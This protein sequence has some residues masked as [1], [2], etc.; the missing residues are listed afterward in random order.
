[1]AASRRT[2]TRTE[3]LLASSGVVVIALA[4]GTWGVAGGRYD[5]G[6]VAGNASGLVLDAAPVPN[7]NALSW[8]SFGNTPGSTRAN[9]SLNVSLPFHQRWN[10]SAR[11]LVELP[12]VIGGGRVVVGS[13]HGLATAIDLQTGKVDWR[14]KLGG[15]V[16]ASAA[17]TGLPGTSSARQPQLDLFATMNG[18][19]IALNPR[20]GARAWQVSLGSS[21]E[22][23][24]LVVGNGI[25]VGTRGGKVARVSLTTHRVVW[26]RFVSGSVK[27]AMALAGS[28]IIV[29]DYS[30]HV[31][32][33]TQ[34]G[35]IVWR[36]T[37]PRSGRFYAGAA[38]AY[39]R[40]YIG[41]INGR[42]LGINAANGVINWTRALPNYV[43]SSAAV[44]DGMVFVG[45][46]NH[47]LYALNAKTGAI[48][49]HRNL[50]QRISG[51]PS[52][53]GNLVWISTLGVP[54]KA[55]HG[56]AFNVK[57]GRLMVYRPLGRFVAAIGVPGT[58]VA[59]GVTT[60]AALTPRTK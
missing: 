50:G 19:L 17:L 47:N 39:G 11:S 31:S 24:P 30:G 52:V 33:F 4:V 13:S 46:Y 9:T 26:T 44:A 35:R 1:M 22:T 29:G 15:S 34:S 10:V 8:P 49:W 45:C 6:T 37:S 56:Y 3:V 43:Y 21:V 16:A 18:H 53:L 14:H 36:T 42:V 28:H 32:A 59:T 27:G 41:N 40:V 23:S 25:F 58:I 12:P 5:Q 54:V 57:T 20:T 2:R 7:P 38:V 51:S 60:I 55:G 48:V